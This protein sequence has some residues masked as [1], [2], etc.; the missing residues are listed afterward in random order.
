MA[1]RKRQCCTPAPTENYGTTICIYVLLFG[2]GAAVTYLFMQPENNGTQHI[3]EKRN[4]EIVSSLHVLKTI[5]NNIQNSVHKCQC[6]KDSTLVD[7]VRG[8]VREELE[9]R[10][11][12]KTGK[13]DYALE[14]AGAYIIST[15]Q[16]EP[17]GTGTTAMSLFGIPLCN[18]S[19]GPNALIQP[20]VMPGECWAFKGQAGTAV[21][22]LITKIHVTGV[23]VEHISRSISPNGETNTAPK[24]FSIWGLQSADDTEGFFFGQ[25]TY[26]MKGTAVQH[27]PVLHKSLR[28]FDIIEFKVHS[29]HGHPEYTCIYRLRVHGDLEQN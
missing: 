8:V 28:M 7:Q 6:S 19:H 15:R 26:D 18:S 23:S 14:S 17:Y 22:R 21:I 5:S 10:N 20:G 9:H 2:T 24:D 25:Y 4:A 13:A 11:A 12:D 3:H 16:T 29:N 1:I 27:F